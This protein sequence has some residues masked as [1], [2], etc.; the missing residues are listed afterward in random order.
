[1]TWK[2]HTVFGWHIDH[3]RPCCAFDLTKPEDQKKCFHHTN[4]QPLWWHENLAK[5]GKHTKMPIRKP[6]YNPNP[7][8]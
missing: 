7:S 2:N 4:L 1:M 5:S 8:H 6:A 3:V